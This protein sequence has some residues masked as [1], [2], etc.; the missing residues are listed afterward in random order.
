MDEIQELMQE[1]EL[2]KKDLLRDTGII[3]SI[4]SLSEEINTLVKNL[5]YT[6]IEKKE[7]PKIAIDNKMPNPFHKRHFDFI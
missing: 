4:N 1:L 5:S 3:S 7:E 6:P 2:V